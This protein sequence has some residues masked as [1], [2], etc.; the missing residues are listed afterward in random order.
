MQSFFNLQKLYQ[1]IPQSIMIEDVDFKEK[2]EAL[3]FHIENIKQIRNEVHSY[4]QKV[5]RYFKQ[6]KDL[7][8]ILFDKLSPYFSNDYKGNLP[9]LSHFEKDIKKLTK[10]EESLAK[11][12]KS[13]N[14]KNDEL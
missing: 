3:R 1:L 12:I 9:N 7:F 10:I 2:F 6:I 5:W 14:D 11:Y 13:L 8:A 4:M